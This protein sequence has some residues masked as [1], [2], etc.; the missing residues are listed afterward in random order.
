[1][2]KKRIN[3]P[4][5]A[6]NLLHDAPLLRKCHSHKIGKASRQSNKVKLKRDTENE[7]R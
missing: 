4:K 1:M 7:F 5:P 3:K 6:R 2:M